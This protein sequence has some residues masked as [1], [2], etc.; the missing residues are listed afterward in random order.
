[1][2]EMLKYGYYVKLLI[3][4]YH[5]NINITPDDLGVIGGTGNTM[6]IHEKLD[7]LI[8]FDTKELVAPIPFSYTFTHDAHSTQVWANLDGS[9][10]IGNETKEVSLSTT[11]Y[12]TSVEKLLNFILH[13]GFP[14]SSVDEE[15]TCNAAY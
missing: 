13:I 8:K 2:M 15:S 3:L 10:T 9:V 7:T 12:T 4:Y 1:M 11:G 14:D 5:H 6:T